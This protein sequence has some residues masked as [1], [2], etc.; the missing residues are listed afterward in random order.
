MK[1]PL[2]ALCAFAT[3]AVSPASAQ[4]WQTTTLAKED[5]LGAVSMSA[6][7]ADIVVWCSEEQVP[8][9]TIGLPLM[10][11]PD[12][13]AERMTLF[14]DGEELRDTLGFELSP[15][16]SGVWLRGDANAQWHNVRWLAEKIAGGERL[17][18]MVPSLGF[19]TN[20]DLQGA[21]QAMAPVMDKCGLDR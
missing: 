13:I 14:I 4:S 7:A 17:T 10:D 5:G 1:T 11:L 20:F 3:L 9:V 18:V 8:G 16:G 19:A 15:A 12:D 2:I 21:G 6:E